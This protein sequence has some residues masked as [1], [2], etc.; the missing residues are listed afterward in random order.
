VIKVNG[1]PASADPRY[2][3]LH[4]DFQDQVVFD[5]SQSKSPGAKII[6]YFWNF[7]DGQSSTKIQTSH[8][9]EKQEF[10]AAVLRVKDNHG[11]ISDAFVGLRNDEGKGTGSQKQLL[12]ADTVSTLLLVIL[13]ITAL[14]ILI[15]LMVR[16]KR[17]IID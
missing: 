17:S 13:G 9:Y 7:G 10:V 1:L 11:F 12:S 16:R 8:Q 5:A 3:L 4:L 6:A 15:G 14:F 2:N